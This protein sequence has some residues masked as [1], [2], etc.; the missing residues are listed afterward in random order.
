MSSTDD[1]LNE[2]DGRKAARTPTKDWEAAPLSTALGI[3]TLIADTPS[4]SETGPKPG[5]ESDRPKPENETI[6]DAPAPFSAALGIPTLVTSNRE[7]EETGAE[8]DRA[9]VDRSNRSSRVDPAAPFSSALGI[10]T[11]LDET[12]T[13]EAGEKEDLETRKR[14]NDRRDP[15][16]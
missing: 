1:R 14:A 13:D 6:A 8:K 12:P 7:D 11:L 3:P 4:K 16:T 9:N 5:K 2:D 15:A 10:P